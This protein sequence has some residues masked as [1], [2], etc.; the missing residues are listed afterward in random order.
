[1]FGHSEKM[2]RMES[3][4]KPYDLADRTREFAVEVIHLVRDLPRGMV[5]E[6]LG[7]QLL[8][9][10]TS[11]GANYREAR[12]A[13]SPADFVSKITIAEEEADE[14]VYWLQLLAETGVGH[15]REIQKLIEEARELVAI[16]TASGRT[17]R[18]RMKR[19]E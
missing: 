19:K 12:K 11:V 17:A 15:S 10:G 16:L 4:G 1:M 3:G 2:L 13:R 8:R 14:S 9:S 18:A 6:T 5:P 7:K